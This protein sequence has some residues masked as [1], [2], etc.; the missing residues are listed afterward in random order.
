MTIE[1]RVDD[2][3]S[4]NPGGGCGLV[5]FAIIVFL[6]CVWTTLTNFSQKLTTNE[7]KLDAIEKRLELLEKPK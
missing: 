7:I 6:F 4:K 3:E 5:I 1:S 2:L